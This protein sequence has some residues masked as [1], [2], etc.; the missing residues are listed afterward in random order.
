MLF[1]AVR[2]HGIARTAGRQVREPLLRADPRAGGVDPRE[3][4]RRADGVPTVVP[5]DGE[6]IARGCERGAVRERHRARDL[7]LAA[8]L[9]ARSIQ[10]REED[11]EHAAFA[12][13]VPGDGEPVLGR[14]EG[15]ELG[16]PT[17]VRHAHVV[18]D[19][20]ALG[21]H[22]RHVDLGVPVAFVVPREREL[23]SREDD[24]EAPRVA[25]PFRD[26]HVV[27]DLGAVGAEQREVDLDVAVAIVEPRDPVPVGARCDHGAGRPRGRSAHRVRARRRAEPR[28]TTAIGRAIATP[29]SR[30]IVAAAAEPRAD[31]GQRPDDP[32]TPYAH[33]HPPGAAPP[34]NVSG[35]PRSAIEAFARRLRWWGGRGSPMAVRF[36]LPAF[37]LAAVMSFSTVARADENGEPPPPPSLRALRDAFPEARARASAPLSG[38]DWQ[39][40]YTLFAGAS[41]L[42]EL[43]AWPGAVLFGSESS[44]EAPGVDATVGGRFGL[45]RELELV[46]D[47]GARFFFFGD[48]AADAAPGA[49][50]ASEVKILEPTLG[51]SLRIR[52]DGGRFHLD[53]GL[54]AGFAFLLG[55]ATAGGGALEPMTNRDGITLELRGGVGLLLGPDCDWDVTARLRVVG[56]PRVEGVS[57]LATVLELEVTAPLLH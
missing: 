31:S 38:S 32:R 15:G 52:P 13:V 34:R 46:V 12:V 3:V 37:G 33:A 17:V 44:R 35:L 41:A 50:Q 24:V 2:D 9:G 40:R 1:A 22:T 19:L 16:A 25:H 36:S 23:R 28:V 56:Y 47:V 20:G 54:G 14:D 7:H 18:A 55:E 51:A 57:S 26:A 48:L 21:G 53:A 45:T 10:A 43:S 30:G 29:V 4:D 11:L 5:R 27:A 8:D 39:G 42:Y 6:R 49:P